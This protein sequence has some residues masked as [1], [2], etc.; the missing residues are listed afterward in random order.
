[1]FTHIKIKL[2]NHDYIRD[3]DY[4]VKREQ[5]TLYNYTEHYN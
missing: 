5:C 1:M 4:H 2:C 3:T